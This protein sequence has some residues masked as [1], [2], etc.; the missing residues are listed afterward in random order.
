M[1][2]SK[3]NFMKQFSVEQFNS[4]SDYTGFKKNK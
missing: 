3:R 1:N 2:N 4:K